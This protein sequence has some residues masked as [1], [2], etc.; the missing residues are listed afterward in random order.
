[1]VDHFKLTLRSV[2][3]RNPLAR[4]ERCPSELEAFRDGVRT[5]TVRVDPAA[6]IFTVQV[7]QLHCG[8][9]EKDRRWLVSGTEAASAVLLVP[10]YD[11][12]VNAEGVRR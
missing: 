4:I 6:D 3:T 5:A 2:G 8:G 11:V 9:K 7:V 12:R 10:G 1:M